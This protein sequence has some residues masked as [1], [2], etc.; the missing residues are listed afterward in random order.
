LTAFEF[1]QQ[2]LRGLDQAIE[3]QQKRFAT[4]QIARPATAIP[5]L[6]LIAYS[7]FGSAAPRG[8][9][10]LGL[11][12]MAVFLAIATWQEH[13]QW[14]LDWNRESRKF[15][16][17]LVAR[18]MRH[19]DEL[20]ALR[21][22]SVTESFRSELSED[23]DLFGDRSL[24]RWLSLAATESGARQ[25]AIWMTRWENEATLIERQRAVRFLAED[26]DWRIRFW[27]ASHAFRSGNSRLESISKWSDS[28]GFFVRYPWLRLATW[29]G[30]LLV[31]LSVALLFSAYR[32]QNMLVAE[33]GF[34]ALVLAVVSNLFVTVGF[35]GKVH[36]IF[37]WIGGAN[38][39][40]QAFCD[41]ISCVAQIRSQEPLLSRLGEQMKTRSGSAMEA[42]RILRFRMSFV[43]LQRNPLFYFPYWALQLLFLWDFH[44]LAWLESWRSKHGNDIPKWID[45]VAQLETLV[46]AATVADE[47]PDWGYPAWKKDT[48]TRIR[49]ANL[50]HPTIADKARVANDLTLATTTPLLLVTGSNMAGKSTLLRSLGV[51]IALSWVGAPAA[52]SAWTAPNFDLASSIRVKDSLQDGVSFF[53]AEL[54]R[55]KSVVDWAH[56]KQ[57]EQ[58]IPTLILLDEILQGTNSRERKI[59]VQSVLEHLTGLGS[60]VAASTHDLELAKTPLLERIA[61]IVHFREFF[62]T[63]DGQQVMRFDYKM[64]PGVTPTTNALKLLEL[65]GLP[66][67]DGNP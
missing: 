10:I 56:E 33:I 45:S 48:G 22:E 12:L 30:P 23:L 24:Y 46:S 16:R 54:K 50:A 61:Q 26:R 2:K 35:V 13:L 40:L 31:L 44:I 51:N 67:R 37:V 42:L 38:R 55:L 53:M 1:Y 21:S 4:L 25:L 39:E 65:V 5:G 59:A 6:L 8:A 52:C 49:I 20:P 58:G 27:D 7:I 3:R 9:W 15:Y 43:G 18:C 17:R 32:S 62:E 36:D 57:A 28:D 64:R 63:V 66:N 14:H 11:V 19:W 29:F 60:T 47:H 34:G 41:L